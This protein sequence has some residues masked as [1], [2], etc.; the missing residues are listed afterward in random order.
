M[1]VFKLGASAQKAPES[2]YVA[3]T[4]ANE[5]E[6]ANIRRAEAATDSIQ[7]SGDAA[8]V[9][10]FVGKLNESPRER[11][12]FVRGFRTLLGQGLLDTPDAAARAAG[13]ILHA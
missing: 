4:A 8:D 6:T 1:D 11:E 2:T 10:R 9:G 13:G 12:D 3:K 5:R 7:T